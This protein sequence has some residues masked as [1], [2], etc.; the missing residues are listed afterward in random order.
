MQLKKV[1]SVLLVAVM[2]LSVM[3][4]AAFADAAP[5][6]LTDASKEGI[7]Y[8]LTEGTWYID[9]D[10]EVAYGFKID[11][12]N[13]IINLNGHTLNYTGG[14]NSVFYITGGNVTVND[15]TVSGG[16]GNDEV[17]NSDWGVRGGAFAVCNS[18]NVT[19]NDVTLSGNRADWGGGIF[20]DNDCVVTLNNCVI[21]QNRTNTYVSS[22]G[23]NGAA[24]FFDGGTLVLNNT[25][26]TGNVSE[27]G[28]VCGIA[29]GESCRG[30][31]IAGNTYIYDNLSYDNAQRNIFISGSVGY[32]HF[33]GVTV[34][35][36]LG[37]FAKIG[38][39]MENPAQEAFTNTAEANLQYND[40]A[41]LY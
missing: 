5:R 3:P 28:Q 16:T 31:Q 23:G 27:N 6:S 17:H 37:E 20:L 1:L 12:G 36:E 19:M 22:W 29:V 9:S 34:A 32:G 14:N 40:P 13:V 41:G 35:G 15:G 18:A 30:L 21:T 26:I 38:V 10:T 2:L 33:P 4:F 39:A 11:A 7:Y 8:L 24:V 25:R